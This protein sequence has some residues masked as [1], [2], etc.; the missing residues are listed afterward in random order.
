MF[1][2]RNKTINTPSS[3]A[4]E[5]KKK[6]K[7]L[8]P[9]I[10]PNLPPLI[11]HR[12]PPLPNPHPNYRKRIEFQLAPQRLLDSL[13][14]ERPKAPIDGQ[15]R[16]LGQARGHCKGQVV[17]DLACLVA[18]VVGGCVEAGEVHGCL[19]EGGEEG[20]EGGGGEDVHGGGAD[21]VGVF[22]V[23]G[24]RVGVVAVVRVVG[25]HVGRG[26]GDGEL[27][28]EVAQGRLRG[29]SAVVGL[30]CQRGVEARDELRE[31]LCADVL[32]LGAAEVVGVPEDG[33][34]GAGVVAWVDGAVF[35]CGGADEGAVDQ[36]VDVEVGDGRGVVG[37]VC[38]VGF[39]L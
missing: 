16:T 36:D 21:E 23:G 14:T 25:R 31:P 5:K 30:H 13:V 39:H 34:N 17:Q 11:P 1:D 8:Q 28:E 35:D 32:A 10:R 38:E 27:G 33:D 3:F 37:G 19:F 6:L 22:A 2:Q 15:P 24:G 9:H 26:H 29:D 12:L 4:R 7:P 18:F 20:E